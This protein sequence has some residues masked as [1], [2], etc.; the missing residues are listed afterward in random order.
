MSALREMLPALPLPNVVVDTA[1]PVPDL[2][3]RPEMEYHIVGPEAYLAGVAGAN[4]LFPGQEHNAAG[5]ADR[6]AVV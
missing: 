6:R 2:G 4:T 3:E 5:A 1:L